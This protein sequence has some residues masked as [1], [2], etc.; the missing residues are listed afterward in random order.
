[1]DLNLVSL[2]NPPLY[3]LSQASRVEGEFL[4]IYIYILKVNIYVLRNKIRKCNAKLSYFTSQSHIFK[5]KKKENFKLNKK[6]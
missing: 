2:V 5:E 6:I 3:H 4:Y 1:M